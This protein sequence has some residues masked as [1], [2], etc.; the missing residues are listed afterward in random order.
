MGS[1]DNMQVELKQLRADLEQRR[2]RR[3]QLQQQLENS[4]ADRKQAKRKLWAS[5]RAQAIIQQVAR[6]T[7]Q[8]LE[9]RVSELVTLALSG[10]FPDPYQFKL[11]FVVRRGKTEADLLF[12]RGEQE[13]DPLSA[14]GGGVV[15]VAA[16]AL[17]VALWRLSNGLRPVLILDEPFKWIS[18]SYLPAAGEML[19]SLSERMG[20]QII[21]VTHLE[22]LIE[23][24]DKVHRIS[25]QG[26][27]SVLR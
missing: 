2:G 13:I 16:F 24:A 27:V 25:K 12:L 19:R 10:V 20:V 1:S 26:E 22:S 5:E 8:E 14:S 17:R 11:R 18:A 21:M 6:A 9:Y 7:Q 15:D 23:I 3:D 4:E